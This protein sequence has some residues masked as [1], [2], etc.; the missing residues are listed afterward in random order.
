MVD[1]STDLFFFGSL[2][3]IEQLLWISFSLD[4]M[5]G[6]HKYST[7]TKVNQI[8]R[9]NHKRIPQII[10]IIENELK[11]TATKWG[12]E[13]KKKH[14]TLRLVLF[15]LLTEETKHIR[16]SLFCFTKSVLFYGI[17]KWILVSGLFFLLNMNVRKKQHTQIHSK[18]TQ[19][20]D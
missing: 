17:I 1:F 10:N 15:L 20:P 13:R 14:V 19:Y 6:C 3:P 16:Y 12:I 11:H 9:N 18:W 2:P 4:G 8:I 7:M 5:N